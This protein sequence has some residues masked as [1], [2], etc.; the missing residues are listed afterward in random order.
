VFHRFAIVLTQSSQAL[1]SWKF[2]ASNDGVTWVVLREHR[3]DSSLHKAGMSH[4]WTL[5]AV[6]ESYSQFRVYMTD[7]NSN[8]HWYMALSGFEVYGT[9]DGDALA[10]E[11]EEME[12]T[13]ES[14]FDTNGILYYLGTNELTDNWQ[15]P[16]DMGLVRVE[17]CSL[18]HN[19]QPKS[20]IVGRE[21]V[22]C[23]SQPNQD[24]W[25]VIDFLERRIVPSKYTLRH[26]SSYDTEALR[27]WNLEGSTDGTNWVCLRA[28]RDDLSLQKKGQAITFE[29]QNCTESYSKFRIFMTGKNS[30]DHWYLSLSGFELY[31]RML[32]RTGQRTTR[33][34]PKHRNKPWFESVLL[35]HNLIDALSS[36]RVLDSDDTL[37]LIHSQGQRE[38][39]SPD[40]TDSKAIDGSPPSSKVSSKRL[41]HK[42]SMRVW[43]TVLMWPQEKERAKAH[44]K[45]KVP[46]ASSDTDMDLLEFDRINSRFR[47][48]C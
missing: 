42:F 34:A 31:G 33:V 41:P 2:E 36:D 7:Q 10:W 9:L 47:P 23:V 30:N 6:D 24:Q 11:E 28:H 32:V 17:A 15:N 19:S 1:R 39:S 3:N 25:F 18:Q 5:P 48:P 4:T 22:R 8:Q 20:A 27:N 16:A 40:S 46:D 35:V 38:L 13:H 12:F 21:A 45:S 14:D 44:G 29:I 26:Y 43:K 37:A